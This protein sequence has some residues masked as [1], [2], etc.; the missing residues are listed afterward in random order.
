MDVQLTVI[1]GGGKKA[2]RE[3]KSITLKEVQFVDQVI[4]ALNTKFKDYFPTQ[5]RLTDE[6]PAKKSPSK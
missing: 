5:T 3:S 1:T 4:E 6:K 2:N